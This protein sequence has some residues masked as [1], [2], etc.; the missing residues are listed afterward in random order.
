MV[1]DLPLSGSCK[2]DRSY[3]IR[4][5]LYRAEGYWADTAIGDELLSWGE[6]YS[7]APALSDRFGTIT[8]RELVSAANDV[9]GVLLSR[10]M[11]PGDKIVLHLPNS[12]EL[13]FSMFGSTLAG[14]IP[15]L[16]LPAHRG[17]EISAIAG[18]AG[19]IGYVVS[20]DAPGSFDYCDLGARLLDSVDCLEHEVVFEGGRID[21]LSYGADIDDQVLASAVDPDDT[22]VMLVSGGTTGLP[23]LIPRSHNDYLYNFSASSE[24]A[25]LSR[26]DVYL[27]VLPVAHNFALGCP[28]VLGTLRCGGHVVL[29]DSSDSRAVFSVIEARGVTITSAVPSLARLWAESNEVDSFDLSSLRMI[30]VG[31]AKL[32]RELALRLHSV[33]RTKVQQVY[34][35]AEGLL[36]FTKP[37]DPLDIVAN[38]QGTP[39]SPH[40]EISVIDADG[41]RRGPGTVGELITRGPYT[42]GGYYSNPDASAA[43]FD[44]DGFYHTGDVVKLYEDGYLEVVG[45]VKD[46]INR[47]GE[48]VSPSELEAIIIAHPDVTACVVIGKPDDVF[49][50]RIIAIVESASELRLRDILALFAARDVAKFKYPD[51]LVRVS[52]IP[53]TAMGKVDRKEVARVLT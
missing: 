28:G 34:G 19:A 24:I 7:D 29:S 49:G 51:T 22:F 6:K 42:I 44:Q 38:R 10:G 11:R 31:G 41:R 25:E 9:R 32:D 16:C 33:L 47:G 43:S 46:V 35:M 53:L 14:L 39:L 18:T 15:V 26:D 13:F 5:D 52:K 12:R 50:E 1:S 8:Y 4:G 40:D 37:S 30:Q 20:R 3:G 27:A 17:H 2:Q 45:R 23:K 36:C 48:C 21:E